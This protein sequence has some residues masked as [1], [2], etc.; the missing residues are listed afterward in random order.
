MEEIRT[1][2]LEQRATTRLHELAS[3]ERA[4]YFLPFGQE[5]ARAPAPTCG[6]LLPKN[7]FATISR[8]RWNA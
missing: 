3:L 5:R 6:L 1:G 2:L 8:V 7:S 4:R